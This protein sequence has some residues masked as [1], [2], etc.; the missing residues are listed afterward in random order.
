MGAVGRTEAIDY[1]SAVY[2]AYLKNASSKNP[3]IGTPMDLWYPSMMWNPFG[4][5]WRRVILGQ[6]GELGP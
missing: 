4:D 6:N 1:L 5:F 2:G 3:Q